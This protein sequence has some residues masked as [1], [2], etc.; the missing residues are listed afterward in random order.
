MKYT[1]NYKLSLPEGT[2]VVDISVLDANFAKLDSLINGL[3]YKL[4]ELSQNVFDLLYGRLY[5]NADKYP[6]CDDMSLYDISYSDWQ[7]DG[8]MAASGI[9]RITDMT[10]LPESKAGTV[11]FACFTSDND[12]EVMVHRALLYPNGDIY[13]SSK[14]IWFYIGG[15]QKNTSYTDW[16]LNSSYPYAART[17]FE[18]NM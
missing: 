3:Q 9:M 10:G 7:I 5:V 14:T 17:Y 18:N 13:M 11:F 1:S 16:E 12:D 6:V 8:A 15:E 4:N 2:D